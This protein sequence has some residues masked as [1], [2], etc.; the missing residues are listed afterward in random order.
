MRITF[1]HKTANR[2]G[3]NKVVAQYADGLVRR[4][5]DVSVVT[6]PEAPPPLRRRARETLRSVLAGR[7]VPRYTPYPASILDELPHIRHHRVSEA[8]PFVD[9]DFPDADVVVATWW[10]TAEWVS[11]LA[12][13][14]GA[15]AYFI[16]GHESTIDG[17]PSERV[18]ATLDLPLHPITIARFLVEHLRAR[19]GRSDVSHVP[20][21]VDGSRFDAPRRG[22]QPR[23]T[24]GCVHTGE[25]RIKGFDVTLAALFEL[26]LQVP[27]LRV[28]CFGNLPPARGSLPSFLEHTLDPPQRVIPEL[29]ARMDVFAHGSRVE[30]FGLPILEAMACRTPVVST[31]SGAAPELLEDD[32]GR[33]IDAVDPS[34]MARALHD[35][36]SLPEAEW[37]ALSDR[38]YAHAHGYSLDDAT[39][40]FEAA[41]ERARQS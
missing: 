4:G 33:M 16:Q 2:S 32:R 7:G 20:N 9:A 30:G 8:R 34:A 41:L 19:H 3:G 6:G 39:V 38:A 22:K 23:P 12:P 17:M 18:E 40:R 10:E 27:D 29:Y 26:K 14:K 25:A 31:P 11:R 36:L 35:V 37:Q 15:K 1:V 24:V 28:V 21:A 13:S 5:H